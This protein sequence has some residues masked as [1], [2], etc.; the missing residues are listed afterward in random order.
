MK[1]KIDDL[2]SFSFDNDEQQKIGNQADF[3]GSIS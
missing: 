2:S 1:E 3:W